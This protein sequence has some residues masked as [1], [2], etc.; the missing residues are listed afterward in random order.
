MVPLEGE[1][2][3]RRL[4]PP[5]PALVGAFGCP[6]VVNNVETLCAVPWI[7]ANGAE[8]YRA[9]GTE[10]SAGT[11]LFCMSGH[12]ERPGVYEIPLG[13]SFMKLL[14]D[15]GG[16]KDGK[17]LKAVIPGG[18]S[19]PVLT[20][21]ECVDLNL[22]YEA[23]AAKGSMLG[24]GGCIVLNEETCMVRALMILERF[25]AHES[26]G[27][28]TPCREGTGWIS[29]IVGRFEGGTA[30]AEEI[31]LILGIGKQMVGKTICV[32]ADAAEMPARS[33]LTKFRAEFEEHARL[34]G[35]PRGGR[36]VGP[37]RE[38]VAV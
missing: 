23:V 1:K 9:Y 7:I 18:S 34:G 12:V 24:S 36:L 38:A 13:Y 11:K 28:C 33:F 10:K 16:M 25:Y 32:L 20:A 17:A 8:A 22:D 21:E 14:E 26:C 19:T 30:R 35:C 5:F 37:R 15:C 2:G 29:T 31:D 27:Q 3:Q 4:K 6:T